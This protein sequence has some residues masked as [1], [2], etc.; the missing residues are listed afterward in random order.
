MIILDEGVLYM[1]REWFLGW[2]YV[3]GSDGLVLW[4][5]GGGAV[6]GWDWGLCAVSIIMWGWGVRGG[7]WE[8]GD[9][10]EMYGWI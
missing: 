6:G 4:E 3:G 2:G 1:C 9:I 8:I 7:G 10:W 5:L